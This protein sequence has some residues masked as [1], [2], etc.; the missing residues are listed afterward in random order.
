[1]QKLKSPYPITKQQQEDLDKIGIKAFSSVNEIQRYLDNPQLIN[2]KSQPSKLLDSQNSEKVA[3][4][5]RNA[6]YLS[7]SIDETAIRKQ[8]T[9]SLTSVEF[10][11]AFNPLRGDDQSPT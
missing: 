9:K 8:P 10:P 3:G 4:I 5:W 11:Q 1:V 6:Y 2:M 7:T